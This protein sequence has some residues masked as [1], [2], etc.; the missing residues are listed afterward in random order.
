MRSRLRVGLVLPALLA[1]LTLGGCYS[2]SS[3]G[4][5][6][7]GYGYGYGYGYGG[8]D[9]G[10]RARHGNHGYGHKYGYGGRG[11]SGHGH[12]GHGHHRPSCRR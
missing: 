4:S 12:A 11:H 6:T 2:S 9:C 7:K 8:A 10:T 1:F 5:Y 3:R